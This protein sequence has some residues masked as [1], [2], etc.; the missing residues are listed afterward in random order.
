VDGEDREDAE[1]E[2]RD[3]GAEP[4]AREAIKDRKREPVEQETA[5]LGDGEGRVHRGTGN[6]AGEAIG[7]GEDVGPEGRG[8]VVEDAA[9]VEDAVARVVEEVAF[10]VVL[11]GPLAAIDGAG[12][13]DVVGAVAGDEG[14]VAA[15]DPEGGADG[16]AEPEEPE[17]GSRMAN[18]GS[19]DG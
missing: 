4:A 10:D 2:D 13:L 5:A 14:E 16:E 6:D 17:D 3:A 7:G 19:R 11:D 1:G 12:D 18:H 8:P 15:D 9:T